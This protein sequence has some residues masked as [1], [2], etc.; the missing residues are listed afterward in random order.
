[1]IMEHV[2]GV[3][4]EMIAN[5][6]QPAIATHPGEI[7]K[8]ELEARGVSQRS[9]AAQMGVSSSL[10]NEVLNEKRSI[11]PELALLLEAALGIDPEPLL[12]MQMEYNLFKTKHNQTFLKKLEK[13]KNVAAVL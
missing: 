9:L 10:L 5:N 2:K 7:L 4:D 3:K 6:L 8:M 1:M 13:I 12:S 11:N